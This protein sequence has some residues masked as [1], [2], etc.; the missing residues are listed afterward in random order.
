MIKL[1]PAEVKLFGILLETAGGSGSILRVAGGWVRDKLLGR[2]GGNDIDVAV[3]GE[4]G[5]SF[6]EKLASKL[7]ASE[8][9]LRG[10]GVIKPNPEK[11]K[12]LET[13]TMDLLGFS[14]DFTGLRGEDYSENS[15][16]P[17]IVP[18]TP[19]EDSLRRDFTINALFYN[20]HSEKI[21]DFTGL[22]VG[23][24]ASKLL[25]TPLAPLKTFFDDPLRVLRGLRF[26]ARF[27]FEVEADT[28]TAMAHPSVKEA[29][30]QKVS[31]ERVGKEFLGVY[32]AAQPAPR[33]LIFYELAHKLD[34]L[35]PLLLAQ[36]SEI[37]RGLELCRRAEAGHPLFVARMAEDK[38]LDLSPDY[39]GLL[40]H[41][42][43]LTLPCFTRWHKEKSN[44]SAWEGLKL[45]KKFC[46]LLYKIQ[47]QISS[48]AEVSSLQDQ[49][50][51]K[52]KLAMWIRDT[53]VFWRALLVLFDATFQPPTSQAI[54]DFAE[55][56][57]IANFAEV[58][59]LFDGNELRKIFGLNGKEIGDKMKEILIYQALHPTKTKEDYLKEH[60]V[61]STVG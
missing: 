5:A 33:P 3:A 13:A 9:E 53:G 18:G 27:G 56:E 34:T 16:V 49:V 14:I 57:L 4:S 52:V 55:T 21:E 1:T 31:R 28:W 25:R 6:A 22:G 10:Y 19:E 61:K 58:K 39:L 12:H 2:P 30:E 26:A 44:L 54:E 47:T 59:P 38:N 50:A 51:K 7:E 17:Q 35:A 60:L 48:L 37:E 11:S 29:L 46:D 43:L 15:R 41:L 42:A 24:L 36:H 8:L 45:S 23:D 20:L 40:G 32:K